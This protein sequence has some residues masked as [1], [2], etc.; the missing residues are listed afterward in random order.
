MNQ[1]TISQLIAIAGSI[2]GVVIGGL[3]TYFCSYKTLKQER[4]IEQ[5]NR[6]IDAK[7]N[8]PRFIIDNVKFSNRMD[9]NISPNLS[10]V[11]LGIKNI[12]ARD[13]VPY[14]EFIGENIDNKQLD[15]L[16]YELV[17][18]GHSEICSLSITTTMSKYF[19]IIEYDSRDYY[20]TNKIPNISVD[21]M[22]LFVK[23]GDRFILRVYFSK[24][25]INKNFIPNITLWAQD[26]VDYMWMQTID[27]K[28]KQISNSRLDKYN[29]YKQEIDINSYIDRF[30]E[31]FGKNI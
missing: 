21:S 17:N 24:E 18:E 5:Q 26:S 16:D 3:I 13:T 19:N 2:G 6:I 15:F 1:E 14:F 12:V 4:K 7:K 30:K 9:N 11:V 27:L 10:I 28:E 31:I 20:I 8:R 29:F 23:P 25:L 22:D